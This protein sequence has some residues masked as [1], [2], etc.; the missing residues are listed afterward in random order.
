MPLGPEVRAQA[1]TQVPRSPDVERLPVPVA[2]D[3]DAGPR[4]R[5]ED[6]RALLVHTAPSGRGELDEVGDRP[7]SSL[8]RQSDE[9]DQDLGGCLSV[10]KR[11]VARSHGGSKEVGE[12]RETDAGSAAREQLPCQAHRVNDRRRKS[13]AGDVL[14]LAVEKRE[15]EAGVVRNDDRAVSRKG[16]EVTDR[17]RGPRGAAQVAVL[18]PGDPGD[19]RR[20]RH[21]RVDQRLERSG[22][23]QRL[24][25]NSADLADRRPAR[26]EASRLEVH[27]DEPRRLE[28]QILA[29]GSCEPDRRPAP[30]QASVALDDVLEQA[31]GE[32]FR[33]TRECEESP[34]RL[35]RGHRTSPLLDELHESVGGIESELHPE[36]DRRTC[37][38]I[39][40]S[41][42]PKAASAAFGYAS[43]EGRGLSG[44]PA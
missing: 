34:G 13:A 26:T 15:I 18:E 24:D 21:A 11:T 12:R 3:V 32:V 10:G 33:S 19:D 16:E 31:P 27:D 29:R 42:M 5:A 22:G 9:R 35:A 14:H 37:V 28:Q 8:L 17:C 30:G 40:A 1:R 43:A 6:E 20:N 23:Q 44:E 36:H 25:P 2:K 7:G 38:R 39:Q 4:R 41:T